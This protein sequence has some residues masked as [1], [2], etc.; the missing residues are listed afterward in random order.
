VLANAPK[1]SPAGVFGSYGWS[2]E[3][4]DILTSKL[5]DAGYNLAFEP[6]KIKFKPTQATLQICEETGTD[7]AQKH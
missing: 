2:G 6:I 3:A 7:F 1:S 4:V 5:Q